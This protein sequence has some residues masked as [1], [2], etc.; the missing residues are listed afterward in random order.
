[1]RGLQTIFNERSQRTEPGRKSSWPTSLLL[2]LLLLPPQLLVLLLRL[3]LLLPL[4]LRRSGSL[5][6]GARKH[7]MLSAL[8][9]C[10]H[11]IPFEM[12]GINLHFVA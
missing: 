4:L 5:E 7:W 11:L 1:M 8:I 6:V 10:I 3:M 12:H 9:R 2:L